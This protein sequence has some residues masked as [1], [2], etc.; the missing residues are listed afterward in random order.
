[1]ICWPRIDGFTMHR[2]EPLP[3]RTEYLIGNFLPMTGVGLLVGKPGAGKSYLAIDLSASIATGKLF[4]GQPV[5][6]THF[7][8]AP[9][10]RTAGGATLFLAGEGL[11]TYPYRVEAA[12][13]SLSAE[14][15]DRLAG[16]GFPDRLP[17]MWGPAFDL[18]D[19]RRFETFLEEAVD[20]ANHLTLS[21][22]FDLRL[23]VVD[24]VPAVFGFGDEN[25]AADAQRV[26]NKLLR[27][28]RATGTFVLGVVHPGKHKGRG[29]VRG[30]GVFEGSPDL[31][32]SAC[33]DKKGK[34]TLAV[35]KARATSTH[36]AMWGYSLVPITLPNGDPQAYVIGAANA[37]PPDAP[38]ATAGRRGM[39]RDAG[40]VLTALQNAV[41]EHPI[42]WLSPAGTSMTG[43]DEEAIRFELGRIKPPSSTDASHSAD[44]L[45]QTWSRGMKKLLGA[46]IVA[47]H[48]REDGSAVYWHVEDNLGRR[49]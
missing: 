30:S 15:R 37:T 7:A 33:A 35:T 48:E 9:S 42:A 13:L 21:A 45:R 5:A 32:L 26:F 44:A 8:E 14:H 17:V 29:D 4:L 10:R 49:E 19:D 31:I 22:P 36:N 3:D 47:K 34:G 2:D 41:R 46:N 18:R 11:E 20:W 6:A 25:S 43:A 27:L 28:S 24:T 39:G 12:Y 38:A 40:Y 23:I 1:M 16:M